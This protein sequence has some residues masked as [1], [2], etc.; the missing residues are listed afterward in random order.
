MRKS[1]VRRGQLKVQEMAFVLVALMVF[2]A[3]VAVLYLSVRTSF[4]EQGVR[5]SSDE[6]ARSAARYLAATPEFAWH[7]CSGCVDLDK[8]F[9]LKQ[10][11]NRTLSISV[12]DEY[13]FLAFESLYPPRAGGE[14]TAGTYPACNRTTLI[15]TRA[16]YGIAVSSFVTLCRWD[17]GEGGVCELGKLY[18][19]DQGRER[20]Q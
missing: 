10:R 8:V 18:L 6:R 11:L 16:D 12:L 4:L 19:S 3:L 1:W 17:G 13:D 5:E 15:K 20:A 9:L 7:A 2:F 14:C